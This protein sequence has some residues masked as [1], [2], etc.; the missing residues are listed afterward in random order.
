MLG[1]SDLC[2]ILLEIMLSNDFCGDDLNWS[3]D[4]KERAG[5]HLLARHLPW[6]GNAVKDDFDARTQG[7]AGADRLTFRVFATPTSNLGPA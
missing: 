4:N 2:R 7:L 3:K 1:P 5:N 6:T